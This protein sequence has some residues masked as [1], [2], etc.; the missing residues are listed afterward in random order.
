MDSVTRFLE[1]KLMAQERGHQR[2]R[3]EQPVTM[4]A[5]GKNTRS[6][7]ILAEGADVDNK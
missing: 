2:G 7:A 1:D 3:I 5:T 4:V 6:A